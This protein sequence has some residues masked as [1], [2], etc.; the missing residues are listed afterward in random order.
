[1]EMGASA[2]ELYQSR[3]SSATSGG[4]A[5]NSRPKMPLAALHGMFDD[6]V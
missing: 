3:I 1:M 2:G 5:I 4:T 6:D